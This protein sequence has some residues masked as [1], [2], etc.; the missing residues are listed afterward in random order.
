MYVYNGIVYAGTPEKPLR[1]TVV[2]PLSD[3]RLR[4]TFSTGEKKYFDVKPLLDT[5]LYA[6]LRDEKLFNRAYLDYGV[7]SWNDG[8]IDIATNVLYADGI[9]YEKETA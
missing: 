4:I 8:A 7:V 5:A 6:P 2:E 1:V 9:A 3:Y